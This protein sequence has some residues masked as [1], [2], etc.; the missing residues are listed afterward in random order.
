MSDQTKI[1]SARQF[2]LWLAALFLVV[3][4]AKLWVVQL[5]GSPLPLWDQWYEAEATFRPWVEGRLGWRDLFVPSNEHRIVFTRL[6]DLGIISLNGRWEPLLQMTVNVLI[7]AT[8]VVTLAFAL[9]EFLGRRSGWLICFLLAPF[10]ALPY[11]AENTI[12]AINSQQ[13]FMSLAALGT[14]LG[15]GFGQV[16]S[17][18]WWLG[19]AAAVA[20]LGTMASGFLAALAVG[21][22]IILR[23]ITN[24]R[25][26]KGSVLTFALCVVIAGAG[27]AMKVSMPDDLP[28]RAHTL[29]EFLAALTRNLAWPFIEHPGLFCL[30]M[31]LPLVALLIFY[32]RKYFPDTRAAEFLLTLG[33]W[34]A[35]Q[36]AAIAFGRANYGDGFPA[37]RY[38]DVLNIFVIAGFFAGL[39]LLRQWAKGKAAQQLAPLAPLLLAGVLFY[40][41]GFISQIVVDQLLIPSRLMNL[42]AEERVETFL[43]T[44]DEKELFEKPT[45]RPDPK[46]ILGVLQNQKLKPIMPA[47][48]F[49][50][51]QQPAPGFLA[52]AAAVL[53]RQAPLILAAGLGLFLVLGG[54]GLARGALGFPRDN[55]SGVLA[56]LVA[57]TALGFVWSR[58]AITRKSVEFDL[59]TKL[60]AHFQ[61]EN[62][63]VRAAI[64]E[65]KAEALKR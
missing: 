44:G 4:G 57:L 37:S 6:L 2:A 60:A 9:W 8:F 14:V 63:P 29:R 15:L 35:L 62:N 59:Q 30:A 34:S 52:A 27:L 41:L 64:H 25:L 46:V 54:F 20:G 12:W 56:L 5:Y 10:Y 17:W 3:V 11:A 24:R 7:H 38:M 42:V 47:A 21:G 16:G 1:E 65:R 61:A 22:L 32:A 19:V 28:L 49:A 45:V 43:T 13:Y 18:R 50:P 23:V 53:L 39:L 26:E 58:S 55:L 36:A 51:A 31:L 48:C 33:L 40:Q